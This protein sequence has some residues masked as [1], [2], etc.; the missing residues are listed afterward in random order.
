M[1]QQ[2]N[3]SSTSLKVIIAILAILL[4]GSLFYIYKL[5]NDAK[6][7]QTEFTKTLSEK[8]LVLKDLQ[9]LKATYDA[10]IAENTSMSEELIVERDKVVNLINEVNKS[11]GDA[12]KY[13]SQ[14]AKLENNM[15]VLIAE[16]EGLKKEN[17]T[18]TTQRDSTVVV[19]G[20]TKKNVEALTGQNEELAKVVEKGSKL[21]VLN[22]KGSAFRLKSSGKQ[23]ETEKAGR[24]NVLRIS[25]TIAEN[26]IAKSGD[27]SYYVQVIDSKNNVLGDKQTV[28]F[29]EKSLTYSFITNVK[30]ENKTVQVS[31]DLPGKDFA[32]GTYFVNIFDQDQ[33]VSKTSFT[34]K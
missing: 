18:L 5:T 7:V 17:V 21:T 20:E 4:V 26:Q 30:Y 10:A 16:N 11:K 13:R 31:Q 32:K 34:L 19:L 2:Q 24:A 29:E 8:E 23:I 25:F 14:Y 33:L 15:K 27:K 12:S 9:E 22:T 28:S 1:E 6:A 3:N